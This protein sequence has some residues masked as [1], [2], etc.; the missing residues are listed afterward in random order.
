MNA[1]LDRADFPVPGNLNLGILVVATGVCSALLWLASHASSGWVV[2]GAS[3]LFS[4]TANTMFSLLHEAVHGVLHDNST[5]NRWAGRWA[6]A[7]F[8]TAFGLQRGFHLVHHRN[9]RSESER[10]DYLQDGDLKWLKRAQ[11]YAILTGVYWLVSVVGVVTY[12][13]VPACLRARRLRSKQ[14][15]VAHQTGSQA[16][17]QVFDELPAIATRLEVLLSF[18]VQAGLFVVLDLSLFGWLVC[19]AA[20]GLNW[21]SLQYADHAFSPLHV[22]EGAWNL[23]VNPLSRALFLNY[24]YHLAHHRHP[25]V[26][27]LYLGRLLDPAEPQPSYFRIW[28][29]MWRGPQ[30]LP[31]IA[32]KV[33]R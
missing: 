14:S 32:S 15:Q 28:V 24:H 19:Y 22:R 13:L 9:N 31:D 11:W 17:L 23:R 20:F 16:Y 2:L 18:A 1:S 12:L 4:F 7:F 30:P 6:A 26:P 25:K 21:S 27:W 5:V 8:P 10:F 3:V 29:S 33:S